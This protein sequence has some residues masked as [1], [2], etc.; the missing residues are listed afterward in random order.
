MRAVLFAATLFLA[1]PAFAGGEACRGVAGIYGPKPTTA[2]HAS[3][4]KLVHQV[5]AAEGVDPAALEAI[6][7]VE[8]GL[9]PAVGLD[10]ELGPFQVMQFWSPIFQLASPALLWDL[11]I[12]ATAAARVYK[13]ALARFR[14]RFSQLAKNPALRRAGFR[15]QKLDALTFAALAYHWGA[16]PKVLASRD[17]ATSKIPASAARYAVEFKRQLAAARAR[18]A[19]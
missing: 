16:A 14:P 11:R 4:R 8:T 2:Q 5:A 19:N 15:G 17:P 6:A 1:S 7:M 18:R 3:M 12:N 9:R 10:C 13:A